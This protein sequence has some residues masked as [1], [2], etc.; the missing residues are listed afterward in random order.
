MIEINP[1]SNQNNIDIN[2]VSN[3]LLSEM[4]KNQLLDVP[5]DKKLY[6]K[7]LIRIVKNIKTS[8]FDTHRCC[9]WQGYITN[10]MKKNKGVYINF[11]YKKKKVALHRLLYVNY[12]GPINEDEYLKFI[13]ENK[14][15]C[16]NINCLK[17][18]KYLKKKENITEDN[19]L[20]DKISLIISFN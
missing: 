6:F 14:G 12:I 20:E 11:Y 16:C 9:I 17:K 19:L 8:I 13:C 4:I 3:Q 7:D 10:L 18:I 5:F 1:F 2:I 15:S